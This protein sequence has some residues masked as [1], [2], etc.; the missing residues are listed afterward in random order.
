M[1]IQEKQTHVLINSLLK[2]SLKT[3][4]IL[5]RVHT[6]DKNEINENIKN[7]ENTVE[8]TFQFE[9]NLINFDL[10]TIIVE[11]SWF[12]CERWIAKSKYVR[13]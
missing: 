12:F 4:L 8:N 11:S 9:I 5:R 3:F 2:F 6:E 10:H 1:A 7:A 13:G